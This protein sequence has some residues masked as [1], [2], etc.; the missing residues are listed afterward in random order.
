LTLSEMSKRIL[1]LENYIKAL[2]ITYEIK[3]STGKIVTLN[4]F[5]PK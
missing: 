5:I 2:I 4:D 1:T 3:D